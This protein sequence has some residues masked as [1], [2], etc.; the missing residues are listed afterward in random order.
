VWIFSI[1]GIT[2]VVET[3]R[4]ADLRLLGF[5][6]LIFQA[7]VALR[8]YRWRMLLIGMSIR[9]DYGRILGLV[10]IGE[11]FSGTLPTPYAGDV[12]RVIEFSERV[13]KATTAGIVF[14][15]RAL[16]LAGLLIVALAAIL[17]GFTTLEVETAAA[18]LL[19]TLLGLLTLYSILR[20]NALSG[21]LGLLPKTYREAIRRLVQPFLDA[22]SESPPAR[23]R[24]A[25]ALSIFNTMLSVVNHFTV[26]A[27]VGI[28]LAVG[29]FFIFA[30]LVNLSL[31]L[32]TISG[33]GL[34][35]IGYSVLLAPFQIPLETAVALGIGVFVSRLSASLIGGFVYLI[36]NIR[37]AIK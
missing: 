18:L 13:S 27:A 36:W 14:L 6:M 2:D 16:G 9:A 15:D 37:R 4:E 12:V 20:K 8:A 5:S 3:L 34:R 17:F 35:E 33:L 25:I 11:F 32:P 30:P 19:I 22:L 28:Q 7:G 24:L 31:L 23:L 21:F 1:V 26:A 29:L 10:Y